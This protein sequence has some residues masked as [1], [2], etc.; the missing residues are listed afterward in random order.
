MFKKAKLAIVCAIAFSGLISCSSDDNSSDTA[1]PEQKGKYVVVAKT[2]DNAYLGNIVVVN[3]GT[4]ETIANLGKTEWTKTFDKASNVAVSVTGH[5]IDMNDE[6][7]EMTIQ[8][9]KNGKVEKESKAS[10]SVLVGNITF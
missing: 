10:G 4:T 5:A 1:T 2:T 8:L 3:N 7:A 9:L 6:T